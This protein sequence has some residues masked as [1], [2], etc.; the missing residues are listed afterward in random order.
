MIKMY[1]MPP[2]SIGSR[3]MKSTPQWLAGTSSHTIGCNNSAR[4]LCGFIHWLVTG[5]AI[6]LDV[7]THPTPIRYL[8]FPVQGLCKAQVKIHLQGVPPSWSVLAELLAPPVPFIGS[9]HHPSANIAVHLPQCNILLLPLYTW[10]PS[11]SSNLFVWSSF[12]C[13][14]LKLLESHKWITSIATA[15]HTCC[16][17][18]SGPAWSG[19][20]HVCINMEDLTIVHDVKLMLGQF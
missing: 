8:P 18:S 11:T 5:S 19:H 3:P 10:D 15:M 9:D 6:L 12:A 2:F 20:R 1:F 7:F 16:P 4:F 13:T 14:L 17:W